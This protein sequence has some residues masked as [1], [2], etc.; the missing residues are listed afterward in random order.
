MSSKRDRQRKRAHHHSR[1]AFRMGV[2]R[3]SWTLCRCSASVMLQC[4]PCSI[5]IQ[6]TYNW[7]KVKR[8]EGEWRWLGNTALPCSTRFVCCPLPSIAM[9]TL[10]SLTPDLRHRYSSRDRCLRSSDNTETEN[11]IA[12][13]CDCTVET[14]PPTGWREN[15]FVVIL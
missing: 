14:R 10:L 9:V 7:P 3:G 8:P 6:Q 12:R 4:L 11:L 2:N 13:T 1:L 5:D 15:V